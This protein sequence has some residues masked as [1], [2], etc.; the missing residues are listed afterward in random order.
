MIFEVLI[1]IANY[2]IYMATIDYMVA[3]YGP[4]SASATGGNALARDLLAGISAMYTSPMFTNINAESKLRTAWA[5]TILAILA[6]LVVLPV[7]L[8][9]WKGETI[10]ARSPFAQEIMMARNTDDP[11]PVNKNDEEKAV[12][13]QEHGHQQQ[14][15]GPEQA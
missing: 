8:F 9:Y 7:Y 12:G 3:A 15:N 4:Y 5:S 14:V 13:H 11:D 2:A 6:I 10:R 1:A